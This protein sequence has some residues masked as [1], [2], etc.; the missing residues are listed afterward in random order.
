MN[1]YHIHLFESSLPHSGWYFLVPFFLHAKHIDTYFVNFVLHSLHSSPSLSLPP[2]T[3]HPHT[4]L[5]KVKASPRKSRK[6]NNSFKFIYFIN[7][8]FDFLKEQLSNVNLK[9]NF[10][11]A[12]SVSY[13]KI[14]LSGYKHIPV[15][16]RKGI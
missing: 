9:K 13:L 1:R 2:P 14:K 11:I 16:Y 10:F 12:Y 4:V 5:L 8:S 6:P 3:D 7:G 15:C